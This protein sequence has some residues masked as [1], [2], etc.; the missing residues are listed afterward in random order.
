MEPADLTDRAISP[1]LVLV[2][3]ELA[4]RARAALPWRPWPPVPRLSV[5]PPAPTPV[6]RRRSFVAGYVAFGVAAAAAVTVLSVVPTPDRPTLA[7]SPEPV[8]QQAPVT[9]PRVA[10]VTI[11]NAIAQA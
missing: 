6:G 7:A 9:R 1:E 3:P 4:A 11:L 8:R 2:D 10:T 5:E